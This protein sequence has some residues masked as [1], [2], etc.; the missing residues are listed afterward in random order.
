MSVKLISPKFSSSFFS[1]HNILLL[2]IIHSYW[3]IG[4]CRFFKFTPFFCLEAKD[5]ISIFFF[6]KDCYFW[7]RNNIRWI[8]LA[9]CIFSG[10]LMNQFQARNS[11]FFL[12]VELKVCE[13][14]SHETVRW[15]E[16]KQHKLSELSDPTEL[17]SN[18]NLC[19]FNDPFSRRILYYD[20]LHL[21]T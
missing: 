20:A 16:S 12:F 19:I 14:M 13:L 21:V 5:L 18:I 15:G 1:V 2:E 11:S 6:K 7:N 8:W 4:K 3:F 10:N 9:L 17:N